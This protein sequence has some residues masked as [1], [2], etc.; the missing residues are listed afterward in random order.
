MVG[1][2]VDHVLM[3]AGGAGGNR[4]VVHYAHSFFVKTRHASE[5]HKRGTTRRKAP[6]AIYLLLAI[7]IAT[8]N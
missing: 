6:T 2:M 1:E 7:A 3:T 8:H 4:P 5:G